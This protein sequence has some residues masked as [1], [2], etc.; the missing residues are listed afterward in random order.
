MIRIR[1]YHPNFVSVDDDYVYEYSFNSKEEFL[2]LDWVRWW[3]EDGLILKLDA[4][5][6]D[7]PYSHMLLMVSPDE[8]K[9]YVIAY[10]YKGSDDL[11]LPKW[12]YKK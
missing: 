2:A 6:E 7:S 5:G 3:L 9:W 4:E 8:L 11:D 1:R 10:L 12:S